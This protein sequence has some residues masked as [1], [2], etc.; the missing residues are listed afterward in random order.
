MIIKDDLRTV[1]IKSL[2][3]YHKK[4]PL[5]CFQFDPKAIDG[6]EDTGD[7]RRNSTAR[8]W[9]D[10]DF[11]EQGRFGSK[12]ITLTGTAVARNPQ[13]L[14]A[15]RDDL[16][17]VLA[18]GNFT[19]VGFS[20]GS[21]TRYMSASLGGPLGWVQVTDTW[22]NWKLDL[23]LADPLMYGPKKYSQ[24]TSTGTSGG[25]MSF[26][27]SYPISFGTIS[28]NQNVVL[29]NIGNYPSWPEFIVRGDYYSGFS[30]E[31]GG[32]KITYS[33]MVTQAA[34]VTINTARGSAIVGGIDR[35][36]LLTS[37]Q[38]FSIPPEGSIRPLFRPIQE[39][40]GWVDVVYR[41][42]WV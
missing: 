11:P 41:D 27:I 28:V 36:H 20:N 23:Y 12:L 7:I 38:W 3:L 10:G 31:S 33:G 15:M 9:S 13:E 35:S 8:P 21:G 22:A 39:A 1:S 18:D 16:A 6:L 29:T 32:R 19:D 40:N 34:P 17:G 14:H 37:R 26:N 24:I 42:T 2:R 4:V 25:G 30:I 5:P